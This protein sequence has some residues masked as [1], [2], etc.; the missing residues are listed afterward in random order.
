M[1]AFAR[2]FRLHTP[3]GER[4]DGSVYPSGRCLIDHRERGLATAWISLQ[5]LKD[6]NPGALIEWADGTEEQL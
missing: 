3:D 2:A 4:Y 1:T 5:A 6:D